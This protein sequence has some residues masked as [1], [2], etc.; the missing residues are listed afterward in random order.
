MQAF[1]NLADHHAII[2]R[3][4]RLGGWAD[5]LRHLH[6]HSRLQQASDLRVSTPKLSRREEVATLKRSEVEIL[7]DDMPV[8]SEQ[9]A[10]STDCRLK[11]VT[12]HQQHADSISVA[13]SAVGEQQFAGHRLSSPLLILP[14]PLLRYGCVSTATCS[15]PD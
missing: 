9:P 12:I 11:P 1:G 10:K 2:I 13:L 8:G 3:R 4:N 14:R 5:R 6:A 7:L 15:N